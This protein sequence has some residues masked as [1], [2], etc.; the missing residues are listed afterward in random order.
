MQPMILLAW[1]IVGTVAGWLAGIAM[2]SGG[3]VSTDI[4]VGIIGAFIGELLLSAIGLT[5]TTASIIWSI[6]VAFAGAVVL[7]TAIRLL[8]VRRRRHLF[9]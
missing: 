1:I 5:E 6:V 7:L 9:N 4:V 8:N 2:K 3:G